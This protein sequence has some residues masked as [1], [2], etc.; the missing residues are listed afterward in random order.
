MYVDAHNHLDL[1]GEKIEKALS[2]IQENQIHTLA[3]SMDEKTYLYAKELANSNE[4]IQPCFGIHPW[5]AHKYH[6]DLDQYEKHII[7]S[8]IIG[9]IGLDYHW[10]ENKTTYP[11]QERVLHYFFEKSKEYGKITNLHTKG[12]EEE[13]L[14]AIKKYKLRPPIIHWYSGPFHIFKKLLQYGCYFT[15]GVDLGYSKLTEEMLKYLPMNKILTETD[16]PT[17][18]E[19]VNGEYGYPDYIKGLLEKIATI[20][21]MDREETKEIIY[22]N[23][24]ELLE[25]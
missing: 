22:K 12:A 16:G 10:V 20:K 2:K 8:P 19:W 18:L 5:E 21:K 6:K 15:I 13:I 23:Y 7:E 4:F 11:K 1:Y 9:E 24:M 3:C 25:K 14:E 17:A